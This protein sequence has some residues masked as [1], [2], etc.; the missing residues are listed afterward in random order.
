[1]ELVKLVMPPCPEAGPR[2][3]APEGA[4]ASSPFRGGQGARISYVPFSRRG[5]KRAKCPPTPKLPGGSRASVVV[6]RETSG[7]GRGGK[8]L[9]LLPPSPSRRADDRGT[10]VWK[11][12]KRGWYKK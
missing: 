10:S 6:V 12:G 8:P 1:M 4:P 11:G 9:L 3:K 2:V 7:L 5:H